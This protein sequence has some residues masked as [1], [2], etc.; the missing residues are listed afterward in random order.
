MTI[1]TITAAVT[2]RI[3]VKSPICIRARCT[4]PPSSSASSSA[5]R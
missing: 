3:T 4:T 2:V 1:I 5:W